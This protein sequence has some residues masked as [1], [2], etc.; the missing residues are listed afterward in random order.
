M[1]FNS[2]IISDKSF[3]S[4][5]IIWSMEYKSWKKGKQFIKQEHFKNGN[6]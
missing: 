2:F 5:F 1:F 6:C 4:T 3:V